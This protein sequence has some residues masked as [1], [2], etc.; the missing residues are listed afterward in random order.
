MNDLWQAIEAAIKA[1]DN[2]CDWRVRGDASRG[3][4][5]ALAE[6]QDAEPV[7]W[8]H[9]ECSGECI[10]CLIER[11]VRLAFGEQGVGYLRR[12]ITMHQFSEVKHD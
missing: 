9:P 10:A 12:H 11:E 1:L 7:A 4:R 6:Q 3:L 8:H 2:D 5:A